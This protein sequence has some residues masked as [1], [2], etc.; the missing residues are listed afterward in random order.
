MIAR[1][2]MGKPW[3]EDDRIRMRASCSCSA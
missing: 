3:F 1:F 2:V